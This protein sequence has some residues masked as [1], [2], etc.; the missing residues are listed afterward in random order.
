MLALLLVEF[1]AMFA[2]LRNRESR[3]NIVVLIGSTIAT[4]V[5]LGM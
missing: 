1:E 2:N 3:N 5:C 4:A